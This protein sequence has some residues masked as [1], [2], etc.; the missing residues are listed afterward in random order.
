MEK[1]SR[2]TEQADCTI[3]LISRQSVDIAYSGRFRLGDVRH[4]VGDV[5]L[6]DSI[7]DRQP[8]ALEAGLRAYF[9]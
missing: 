7:F 9:D 2:L 6:Y 8:T 1:G 3:P 5:A 4:A